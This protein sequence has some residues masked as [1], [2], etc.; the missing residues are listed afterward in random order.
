MI[1]KLEPE[2]LIEYNYD[3]AVANRKRVLSLTNRIEIQ[4]FLKN[5]DHFWDFTRT[6]QDNSNLYES[7]RT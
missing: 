2:D 7:Y 5:D 4:R 3:T 1:I 6:L